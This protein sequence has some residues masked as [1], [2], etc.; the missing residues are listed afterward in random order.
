MTATLVS[1]ASREWVCAG[2][3]AW[4]CPPA[5]ARVAARA[6][7]WAHA[8][9][10]ERVLRE[11]WIR[12]RIDLAAVPP[13]PEGV[14]LKPMTD[15]F[16]QCLR[17]HVD[18]DQNQLQS[19]LRFWE[20]GLRRAYMWCD[21]S[22]PLCMQWLLT[23]PDNA[24]LRT[25]PEW[26]GMYPPLQSGWG[27]VE[28]L[29]AFSTARRKGVATQFE[30]ALYHVARD[31]G[32]SGLITHIAERNEAARGWADRAGWQEYGVIVRYRVDLPVLRSFP[33]Y[34]H[35]ASDPI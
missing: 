5:L 24:L 26:A 29:F 31:L 34:L 13:A 18:R 19:G 27:Q 22:G 32:L 15:H 4:G 10:A 2:T 30:Y 11:R 28:N 33:L 35:R 25:L 9:S 14:H 20:H 6:G 8:L 17:T 3:S 16:I 7:A 21:E 1:S 23:R 12:Y